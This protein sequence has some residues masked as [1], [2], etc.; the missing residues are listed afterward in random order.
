MNTKLT[1]SLEKSIIEKAKKYAQLKHKSLSGMIEDYLTDLTKV[2]KTQ[3]FNND[4]PQITKE[5]LGV[6]KNKPE[7]NLKKDMIQFLEKKYK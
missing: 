1:L 6:L 3:D 7:V 5:L 4:L 2:K